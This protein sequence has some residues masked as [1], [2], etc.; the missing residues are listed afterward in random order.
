M[1]RSLRKNYGSGRKPTPEPG[2]TLL[3]REGGLKNVVAFGAAI[4]ARSMPMERALGRSNQGMVPCP[5][6]GRHPGTVV[7]R[8]VLYCRLVEE[9]VNPN[10]DPELSLVVVCFVPF[11]RW[12][13]ARSV[14]SGWR[15]R[16]PN[17]HEA[18]VLLRPMNLF[19]FSAPPS[20]KSSFC[21]KLN[22]T[23]T[24]LGSDRDC[25]MEESS[26][27]IRPAPTSPPHAVGRLVT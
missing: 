5:F 12:A 24:K 3:I 8:T 17:R 18:S 4:L 16:G 13:G 14:E 11:I 20:V 10:M 19:L 2:V 25:D 22:R 27:R 1:A 26:E 21:R 15:C 6:V 23:R 9:V 7:C